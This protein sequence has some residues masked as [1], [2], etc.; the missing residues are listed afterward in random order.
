MTG[1]VTLYR[2]P[3]TLSASEGSLVTE[4]RCFAAL[5]MTGASVVT[6]SDASL[7][8]ARLVMIMNRGA[9]V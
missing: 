2:P 4:K 9:P 3:V 8:M 6:T 5:S 7:W 1:W